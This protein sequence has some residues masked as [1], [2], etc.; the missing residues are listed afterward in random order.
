MGPK[1]NEHKSAIQNLREVIE[2]LIGPGGCPWDCAQTPKT[3]CDYVVEEAFELVEAIR[4]GDTLEAMEELGDV[5]FLLLFIGTLF[6]KNGDFSVNDALRANQAKMIRRHPHVFGDLEVK[7]QDELLQNWERIKRG[8]KKDAQGNNKRVFGSLPKGL[9]P[10]LRAYRINSKAA[11]VGFTWDS[12][13]Q[14]MEQLNSEWKEWEQ[15]LA[16][17]DVPAQER[18]YGDYLFTLVELGRR[19][20]IKANAALDFANRKF[21]ARFNAM[22]KLAREQGADVSDLS[23]DQLNALWDQV[24]EQAD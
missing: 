19:K 15:A 1:R 13:A 9:P 22:E 18:E 2:T 24:K 16:T 11:R 20:G 14:F 17:G 7:T 4:S 10:L 6:E 8:E 21:L 12:D 5:M 3:L 23:L